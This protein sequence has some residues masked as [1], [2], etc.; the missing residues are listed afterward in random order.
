M[1]VLAAA[2]LAAATATT[3]LGLI[4][5][6]GWL[7]WFGLFLSLGGGAIAIVHAT[8][9]CWRSGADASLRS[10]AWRAFFFA[11]ACFAWSMTLFVVGLIRLGL[12]FGVI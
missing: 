2:I 3:L 4:P 1:R 7:N 5:L 11:L 6:L 9:V 12:G 8:G 10:A